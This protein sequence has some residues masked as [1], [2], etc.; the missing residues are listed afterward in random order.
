M[1]YL[2][3]DGSILTVSILVGK[4]IQLLELLSSAVGQDVADGC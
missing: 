2:E 4:I 1:A 3:I